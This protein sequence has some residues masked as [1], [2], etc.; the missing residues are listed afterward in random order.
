MYPV[1]DAFDVYALLGYGAADMTIDNL[2]GHAEYTTDSID[3]FSWGLGVAYSF[4]ENVSI[5]AD[6]VSI[7]DDTTSIDNGVWDGVVFSSEVERKIDTV[8]IGVSYQF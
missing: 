3:G 2:P 8:N 4:N 6:Y 7:Y 1:T 5:F